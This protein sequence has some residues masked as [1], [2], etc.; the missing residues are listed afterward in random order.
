MVDRLGTDTHRTRSL[1][2]ELP[3]EKPKTTTTVRSDRS[4]APVQHDDPPR[5]RAANL[6]TGLEARRGRMADPMALQLRARAERE[7]EKNLPLREGFSENADGSFTFQGTSG[8]DRYTVSQTGEGGVIVTND[9][10]GKKF[11][12]TAEEAQR[13]ITIRA[14]SGDDRI[15][16]DES[17]RAPAERS[18]RF[19]LNIRGGSGNDTIDASAAT[20]NVSIEGDGGNDTLTGGGGSDY[21]QG[22]TGDDVING[23]G[24]ADTIYATREDRSIDAGSDDDADMIIAEEG[25]VTAVN[26]GSNDDVFEF[27]PDQVDRYLDEHPELIIEGDSSFTART[28]AD[29]GVML[30][31]DQ[32]RGLLDE[33]TT[34]LQDQGETLTFEEKPIIEGAGGSY[35]SGG[36]MVYV[37]QFS[38]LYDNG[39]ARAPLPV[40][41]HELVHAHQHLVGDWPDGKT[42]FENGESINNSELQ[43]TGLPYY[44]EDGVLHEANELPYTD[45]QFREE[46][47]IKE[48]EF[49]GDA[50]GE[51]VEYEPR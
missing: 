39:S 16:V 50:R 24:G 37:G 7:L 46:L 14:G 41:F 9:R 11:E 6:Q 26:L 15:T 22:G 30:T 18:D 12:L 23:N 2:R 25:G 44:D 27:D 47:G 40:L 28:R 48:R 8:N 51:P 45:N 19:P 13:G 3:K 33:L 10:T 20:A 34:A 4:P 49:Y 1:Y 32:G 42:R 29:L 35:S 36:N 21:L 31:T 38:E 43:A 5:H 17:L